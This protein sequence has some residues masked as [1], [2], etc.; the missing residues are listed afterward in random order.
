MPKPDEA[1]PLA[2][3]RPIAAARSFSSF[4]LLLLLVKV[5]KGKVPMMLAALPPRSFS[6]AAAD[7]AAPSSVRSSVI[8]LMRPTYSGSNGSMLT[9]TDA[10][11]PVLVLDSDD[12]AA[13]PAGTPRTCV[14]AMDARVSP[15][16]LSPAT[17][18]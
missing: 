10:L 8:S 4:S 1:S 17:P 11:L 16:A 6:G 9:K 5:P 3:R 2:A 7:P 18:A 14:R 12:P 13:D 15:R